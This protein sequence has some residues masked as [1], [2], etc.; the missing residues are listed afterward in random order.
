MLK[1]YFHN[2]NICLLG[3]GREGR[4]T[5]S[6]LEKNYFN[7]NIL[8]CDK[9]PIKDG[10]PE[11]SK[12]RISQKSGIDY[13]DSISDYDIIIKSPGISFLNH[14]TSSFEEKI[15]S[16]TDLFLMAYSSQVIGVTGTKGKSTTSSLLFH[17]LKECNIETQLVGNIGTPLFD[18]IEKINNQ[19]QI[20]AELSCHQLEYLKQSPKIAIL[21]NIFPE[22]L[23]RYV[24]YEAYSKAKIN[25]TLHQKKS[26][27]LII[28]N[29][30]PTIS[31]NK[32]N[33]NQGQKII[34]LEETTCGEFKI[35]NNKIFY[36]NIFLQNLEDWKL[37]GSHNFNNL[38]A[39]LQAAE[40]VGVE[41]K[42]AIDSALSFPGLPHRLEYVGYFNKIHFYNDSIA[43]IPEAT[44][45]A[46]KAIPETNILLLGG[47]DRGIDYSSLYSFLEE[48]PKLTIL[49]TGPAGKRI[50]KMMGN[51]DFNKFFESFSTMVEYAKKVCK[52]E[53]TILLSPAAASYD[54]FGNFEQR[55]DFYK[56]KAEVL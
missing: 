38:L 35:E 1:S 7:L 5:L 28:K 26:D 53:G 11:K 29:S 3:F 19:T 40:V 48:R 55:G 15:T 37:K 43:T 23:D 9:N 30:N 33:W 2:K 31:K 18:I 49:Y 25:I 27:Y 4:S 52:P 6:F 45:L 44:I 46:L 50:Q 34:S 22:H 8:I 20:V 24:S 16:Q 41:P 32:D 54:Q 47:F 51:I 21:L 17:I 39:A 12:N 10:I 42:N 13:L 36:K 56:K 14:D